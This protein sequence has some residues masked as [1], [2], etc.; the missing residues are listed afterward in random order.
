M[1]NY[2]KSARVEQ[3]G[4]AYYIVATF[5]NGSENVIGMF[6]YEKGNQ[7]EQSVARRIAQEY[8]KRIRKAGEYV[9]K[10]LS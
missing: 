7:R 4:N 2:I 1:I 9:R 8:A 5:A 3:Q 10:E 6:P